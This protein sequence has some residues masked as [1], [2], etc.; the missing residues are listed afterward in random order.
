[1][2]ITL[3]ILAF[4]ITFFGMEFVAWFTHKYV[5]HGFLWGLHKDH[6]TGS[7]HF[8]E[9]NDWFAL[10]FAIPSWLLIMLGVI[11]NSP[12]SIIIGS[13]MTAY[14]AA[15]FLVHDVFVHQRIKIL[16]NAKHPYFKALRR[17]HKMH[18]KHTNKE[19]GE[20]F[21]FLIVGRKYYQSEKNS[22][23]GK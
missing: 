17:A 11:Y 22:L 14:G 7:D 21:G 10:V 1:M 2:Q 8:L 13:G 20:S 6:H 3:Y 9:K 12:L 15:Y 16:R 4:I 23:L 5:M 18:H 19:H